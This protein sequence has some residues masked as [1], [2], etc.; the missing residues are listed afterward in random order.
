MMKE[1]KTS[2]HQLNY[3]GSVSGPPLTHTQLRTSLCS[4]CVCFGAFLQNILH[5]PRIFHS[6]PLIWVKTFE[7]WHHFLFKSK[8]CYATLL[9]GTLHLI[10]KAG[11]A[12]WHDE[13][14]VLHHCRV[15]LQFYC[16][17]LLSAPLIYVST[18]LEPRVDFTPHQT[19]LL[20]PLGFQDLLALT[21]QSIIHFIIFRHIIQN[22]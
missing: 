16:H 17:S 13:N 12:P 2:L 22:F 6:G 8:A 21:S 11:G 15:Q 9:I 7:T 14:L 19:V 1:I 3:M 5:S 10:R 18:C 4:D 20:V